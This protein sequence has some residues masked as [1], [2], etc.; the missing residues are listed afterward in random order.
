MEMV[1]VIVYIGGVALAVYFIARIV[2]FFLNRGIKL[3]KLE[4]KLPDK[5]YK[6]IYSD[7]KQIDQDDDVEYGK[8]LR[9]ESFDI[10]GKPDYIYRHKNGDML[11]VELKSGAIGEK[12]E[13]YFG[14]LMQLAAY[15]CIAED[16]Y[17]TR[18]PFGLIVY[19]DYMFKVRNTRKLRRTLKG[20]LKDMRDMLKNGE[21]HPAASFVKCRNCMCNGT[22]CEFVD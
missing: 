20:V 3:E 11:V 10:S 15:F 19:K 21:A 14:D 22:V 5:A 13:P 16:C 6:L 7:Q 4:P 1:E 8:V 12:D 2:S 9:N 17:G 18:T